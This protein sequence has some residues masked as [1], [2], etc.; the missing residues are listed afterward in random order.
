MS[1]VYSALEWLGDPRAAKPLADLLRQ[2]GMG[3]YAS[4]SLA[5]GSA[6][7]TTRTQST[8]E[9]MLARALY[10]CGDWE[11]TG[12]KALKQYAAD[13]RGHYARHAQAVLAAG[14]GFRLGR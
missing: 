11:G 13:L 12:E 6:T 7:E 14:K 10:R 3:G 8:R 9:L 1:A 5:P 2:P 4:E